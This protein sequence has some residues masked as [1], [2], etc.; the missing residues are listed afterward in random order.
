MPPARRRKLS[1][2][3]CGLDGFKRYNEARGYKAGDEALCRVARIIE[4]HAAR[5]TWRRASAARSSPWC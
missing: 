3:F 2:V 5:S 1:L 4:G